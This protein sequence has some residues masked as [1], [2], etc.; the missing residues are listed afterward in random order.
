MMEEDLQEDYGP[1]ADDMNDRLPHE[2]DRLPEIKYRCL[3]PGLRADYWEWKGL[4]PKPRRHCTCE[5]CRT[6]GGGRHCLECIAGFAF[7]GFE[8]DEHGNVLYC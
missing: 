1:L 8:H 6:Q 3:N 7:Y 4:L 2:E 5:G